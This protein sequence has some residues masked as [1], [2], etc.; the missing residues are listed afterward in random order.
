MNEVM[1]RISEEEVM[2]FLNYVQNF[3]RGYVGKNFRITE[4]FAGWVVSGTPDD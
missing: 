2:R 1:E 3:P 4:S